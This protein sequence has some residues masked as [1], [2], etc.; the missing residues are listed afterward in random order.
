M[1]KIIS[2][3][4]EENWKER[5]KLEL[6]TEEKF[7][8]WDSIKDTYNGRNP[9]HRKLMFDPTIW[10]YAFLRSP[11]DMNEPMKLYGFQDKFV[12]DRNRFVS[13]CAANQMG[14]TVGIQVKGLH[15][16]LMVNNATVL[17]ISKTEQQ[18]TR[19]LDEMKWLMDKS[20]IP[21]DDVKG[22]IENRTELH[23]IGPDGI[24]ISRIVILPP[25]S[26][27]LG[28]P[29]TLELLDEVDFWEIKIRGMTTQL[30]YYQQVLEPRT[31]ATKNWNNPYFT[32][33]QIV[34]ISN[35]WGDAGMI[36]YTFLDDDRYSC[37][38]YSWLAN[39]NNTIEEYKKIQETLPADKFDSIYG[40]KLTSSAGGFITGNEWTMATKYKDIDLVMESGATVSLGGDYAG[41]DT[42]SRDVDI[43]TMYGVKVIKR[44]G[45]LPKIRLCYQK[46]WEKRAKKQKV[47]DE[48]SR[49]KETNPINLYAYDKVGVGDSVKNDLIDKNILSPYQIESLTYSLP[50]KSE[51]FY[52]L[53]HL[54]EQGRIEIPRATDE[55]LKRQL[56]GLRFEKTPGG[57]I[58]IHHYSEKAH[59]DHADAFANACYAALRLIKGEVSLS[60]VSTDSPK[61]KSEYIKRVV[62]LTCEED[63]DYEDFN[64][65]CPFCESKEIADYRTHK[66]LTKSL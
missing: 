52:N 56:L 11:I 30:D 7:K 5:D 48:I 13:C 23:L 53:K 35:P 46:G 34:M 58:K 28:Y 65:G 33:G 45:E 27:A 42:R 44:E 61:E 15:H 21:F 10:A 4:L 40:A 49:I 54:F 57:Y 3:I 20:K 9:E 66:L 55:I 16:A 25:T 43:H 18:A 31:N 64:E 12:N 38:Q 39:P 6:E 60:Y 22:P 19:V 29:A 36:G 2:K 59:D 1:G 32:M 26:G 8:L 14:K 17:I 47:Y 41:E 50:N 37:Y 24:S 51:V 62:C 63:G